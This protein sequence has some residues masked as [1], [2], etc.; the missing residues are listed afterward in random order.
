MPGDR[1]IRDDGGLVIADEVQ[2]GFARM[3][4]HFWAFE[5][6]GECCE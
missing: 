3:G 2:T 5:A 4:E 6:Y 1:C